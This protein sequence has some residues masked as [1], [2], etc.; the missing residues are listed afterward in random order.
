[1]KLIIDETELPGLYVRAGSFL[2]LRADHSCSYLQRCSL[3]RERQG[4]WRLEDN[5]IVFQ[6][7]DPA[8][9]EFPSGSD[10]RFVAVVW[11]RRRLLVHE[12]GIPG[13]CASARGKPPPREEKVNGLD[14][15]KLL[16]AGADPGEGEPLIPERF[17]DFHEQGA[18]LASV[19][20]INHDGTVTL[21]KGSADRLRP[22][23]LM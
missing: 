22:G 2:D 18:I 21:D 23:L 15:V 10:G 5:V 9:L 7:S 8:D 1:M 19:A 3:S 13:F 20:Q 14:F 16:P 11:G 17:R 6:P 12:P 4:V